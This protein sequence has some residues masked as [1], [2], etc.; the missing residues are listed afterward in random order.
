M[1]DSDTST[2]ELPAA[3]LALPDAQAP[4]AP[5]SRPPVRERV[6]QALLARAAAGQVEAWDE[7][8]ACYTPRVYGLLLRQCRDPSLA[9]ELTQIT[10]VKLVETLV[11]APQHPGQDQIEVSPPAVYTEQGQFEAYLFRMAMNKLRDEMRRRKRQAIPTDMS[12]GALRLSKPNAAGDPAAT[13]GHASGTP[14][15]SPL[16]AL[17]H[18]EHLQRLRAAVDALPDA[19]REVLH[20]RHTAG[21]SFAQIAQSLDQPL[22][23]VL[24]RAHRA[25]N[26]L[27]H[28]FPEV[29][30]PE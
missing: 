7:L 14:P 26:K 13:S 21:L 23:T 25:V 11:P 12:P 2:P 28:A 20:L 22:G 18:A 6:S 17:E 15:L 5:G 9:E 30:S 24:A 16:D 8:V 3:T 10:F 19:D 27:R 29:Q 1:T 4:P